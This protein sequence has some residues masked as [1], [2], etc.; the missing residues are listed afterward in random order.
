MPPKKSTMS[1]EHKAALAKGREQG[2]VI[3]A[4][5]TAL[6][7]QKPKRGRRRS[8]DS[9]RKRVAEI[10]GE[11]ASADP[12]KRVQ[13]IQERLD[14][15]DELDAS[16]ANGSMDELEAEFTKVAKAYSDSKGLSF[17]AWREVGVPAAVLTQAGIGH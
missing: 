10:D 5:L 1:A 3:R 9:I 6:D 11:L 2:R 12:L 13:L 14:L 16:S 17:A 7:E 4:Y 8:P 15:T